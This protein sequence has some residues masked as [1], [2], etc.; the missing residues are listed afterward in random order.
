[1][2]VA[3][4]HGRLVGS[5]HGQVGS[6]YGVASRHGQVGNPHGQVGSTYGQ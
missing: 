6:T 4:R 2:W 5:P 3:S 1:M